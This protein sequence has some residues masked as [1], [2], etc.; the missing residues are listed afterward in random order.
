MDKK[1]IFQ[2]IFKEL[3][4]GFINGILLG[5][6]SFVS[7]FAFLYI[8][9]KPIIDGDT[10]FILDDALRVSLIVALSLFIA[11]TIAAVTGSLIPILLKKFKIDPAVASGPFISTI[12]DI[13]AV[14]IYYGLATILFI[15]L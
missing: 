15:L 13:C 10:S 8:S 3:R 6:L 9:N 1:K 4:I 14:V 7:V 2:I 5:I 12:N 11:L